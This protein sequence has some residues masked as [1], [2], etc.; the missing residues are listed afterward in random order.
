MIEGAEIQYP[1][2]ASRKSGSR[3]HVIKRW[4]TQL[5]DEGSILF[6]SEAGCG[7]VYYIYYMVFV[8][9]LVQYF[10]VVTGHVVWVLGAFESEERK[11]AQIRLLLRPTHPSISL[12]AKANAMFT[13]K[14]SLSYDKQWQS[15]SIKSETKYKPA[16]YV[17][18]KRR[19]L[20]KFIQPIDAVSKK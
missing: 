11:Q 13:W 20:Q 2:L 5:E 15:L 16:I 12:V 14:I 7:Y 9:I 6:L 18:N 8:Y 4:K 17:M 19:R 3:P 1:Q 10:R